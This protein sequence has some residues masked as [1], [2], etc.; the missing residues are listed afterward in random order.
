[1]TGKIITIKLPL[2]LLAVIIAVTTITSCGSNEEKKEKPFVFL[3]D[4]Y[5][6]GV[7][8]PE[9]FDRG[10]IVTPENIDSLYNQY[11][12]Y[13]LF[14]GD[15]YLIRSK[16]SYTTSRYLSRLIQ[17]KEG[18]QVAAKTFYDSEIDA[19]KVIKLRDKLIIGLNSLR[20]NNYD[21][22]FHQSSHQCR[23]VVLSD[24]LT[25]ILGK[26]FNS[27]KG[28]TYI[29][30]LMQIS[31]STFICSVASGEVE[32]SPYSHYQFKAHKDLSIVGKTVSSNQYQYEIRNEDLDLSKPDWGNDLSDNY[33]NT[34][35]KN[36][37]ENK[38]TISNDSVRRTIPSSNPQK[39]RIP[40]D[41]VLVPAGR[42]KHLFYDYDSN[43]NS[44]Y[45][46]WNVDSFYICK[47]EV[48][49]VEYRSIMDE[50]PSKY[51]GDRI[52]VHNLSNFEAIQYC[53]KEVWPKALMVST[54]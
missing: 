32:I 46:D 33:L 28:H 10:T 47:Y 34:L 11:N 35:K 43:Y 40:K 53:Q 51:Q 3:G 42:L 37:M 26:R 16:K 21:S 15:Y 31:D 2:L 22:T 44:I 19:N 23:V 24:S 41:F 48:T 20:V 49:Q 14:N 18:K 45:K 13:T 25:P 52:P 7:F 29:E 12:V 38:S 54:K 30:S 8:R 4:G 36:T 50:N 39:S 27:Q 5:E 17:M 6:N 1:M 9:N